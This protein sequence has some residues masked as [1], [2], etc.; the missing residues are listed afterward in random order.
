M[1]DQRRNALKEIA[2]LG[3]VVLVVLITIFAA[4]GGGIYLT[5]AALEDRF[6]PDVA[7]LVFG[8]LFVLAAWVGGSIFTARQN[9]RAQDAFLQGL[10]ELGDVMRGTAGVQREQLRGEREAFKLTAGA[11]LYNEKRINQIADQKAR[12]LMDA[13]RQAQSGPTWGRE[14]DQEPWIDA[15][16]KAEVPA[17]RPMQP[18]Q[19]AQPERRER[20]KFRYVE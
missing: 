5:F 7:V 15:D 10:G 16:Y 9:K 20:A 4:L 19:P 8:G 14:V 11:Q 13:Q 1:D 2:A 12:L 17:P 3:F 18:A 6:G